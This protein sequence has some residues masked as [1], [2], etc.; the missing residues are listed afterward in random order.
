MRFARFLCDEILREGIL[1]GKDPKGKNPEGKNP[2][3]KN[4]KGKNDV[5]Y[6]KKPVA[7]PVEGWQDRR[8]HVAPVDTLKEN[9]I[10]TIQFIEFRTISS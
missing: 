9:M 10:S 8:M 7:S 5:I 4:P 6:L 1:K 2:E 3:G